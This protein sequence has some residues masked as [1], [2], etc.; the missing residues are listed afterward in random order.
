MA[1]E[2]SLNTKVVDA[3][4]THKGRRGFLPIET[5]TFDRGFISVVILIGVGLFWL[6]F[7]E[8]ALPIWVWGILWLVVA[9]YIIKKG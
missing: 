2:E 6:R 4:I 1:K 7:I 8:W 3:P 5:N 9:Y